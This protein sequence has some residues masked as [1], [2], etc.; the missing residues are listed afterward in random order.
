MRSLRPK[1][2]LDLK[3][4]S[5]A[6]FMGPY[7]IDLVFSLSLVFVFLHSRIAYDLDSIQ[8]LNFL[9]LEFV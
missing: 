4:K 9:S 6:G 8:C 2:L 5:F 7:L 1:S 3:K